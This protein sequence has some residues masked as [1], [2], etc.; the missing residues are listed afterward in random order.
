MAFFLD[1]SGKGTKSFDVWTGD[2]ELEV[3][4]ATYRPEIDQSQHAKSVSHIKRF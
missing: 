4:T 2:Q 1:Y 3:R